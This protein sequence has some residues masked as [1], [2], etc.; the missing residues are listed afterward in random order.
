MSTFAPLRSAVAALALATLAFGLAGCATER[1]AAAAPAGV[2]LTGEWNFNANLSDDPDKLGDPDSAPRRGPGGHRGHGGRGGGGMPPMGPGGGANALPV[3]LTQAGSGRADWMSTA[4]DQ[5]SDPMQSAGD[6]QSGPRPPADASPEGPA[7]SRSPEA[8]KAPVHLSITQKDGTLTVR[9]NMSDGTRTADEYTA[10]TSGT[11]P[12]GHDQM[13]DRIVGWRGPVFVV[14]LRG[15]KSGWREDDFALDED[16][17]LIVTTTTQKGRM[18]S[19]E[20][21]RVYDRARGTEVQ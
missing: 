17:R 10:G 11:V 15:R 4:A 18:G 19:I 16:G 1:L 2:D 5:Q 9:S 21:K 7:R 12:F 6:R 20:I 3:S 8:A 14:T 13:A